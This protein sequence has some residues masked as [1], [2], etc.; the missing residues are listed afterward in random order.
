[1]WYQKTAESIAFY[2]AAYWNFIP[3]TK[4]VWKDWA[5][6]IAQKKIDGK[7]LWETPKEEI[8]I[9]VIRQLK[10]I[11]KIYLKTFIAT[12]VGRVPS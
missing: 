7:T 8:S 12:R 11:L 3:P 1:M 6:Y 9:E 5:L 4:L 10:E 2:K